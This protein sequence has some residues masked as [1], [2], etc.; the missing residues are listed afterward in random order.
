MIR[1]CIHSAIAFCIIVACFSALTIPSRGASIYEPTE[2][3]ED[4]RDQVLEAARMIKK[5]TDFK[6]RSLMRGFND[7]KMS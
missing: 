2:S 4:Y 6:K 5:W 3:E 1:T 7:L